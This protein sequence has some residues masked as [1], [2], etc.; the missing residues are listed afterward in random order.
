MGVT[1]LPPRLTGASVSLFWLFFLLPLF[2]IASGFLIANGSIVEGGIAS[3]SQIGRLLA[4]AL[5]IGCMLLVRID[6]RIL[7]LG[8]YPVVVELVMAVLHQR[9]QAFL[10]GL[11]QAYKV[12]YLIFAAVWITTVLQQGHRS[13]IL[14]LIKLNLCIIA[15]MLIISLLF[16]VGVETYGDG[17]GVKGYFASG[18]AVGVYLGGMLILMLALKIHDGARASNLFIL[19]VLIATASVGT[20]T[21][22]LLAASALVFWWV[23][24]GCRA[25]WPAALLS[26]VL[27]YST[28]IVDALSFVYKVVL[29]RWENSENLFH[30]LGS[31]RIEYVTN[32]FK[33]YFDQEVGFF[34][35]LAG[36][37]ASVSYQDISGQAAFDTLETDL[38]DVFFMYGVIGFLLYV[39]FFVLVAYRL[40]RRVFLLIGFL[41]VF[42]HSVLAGHVFFNGMNALLLAL[43]CGI[44]G[45]KERV[46][47]DSA[48]AC[49]TGVS[50]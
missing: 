6:A 41:L 19:Y 43:Y 40:R 30:F 10:V 35:L 12:S 48:A 25:M 1:S 16:G 24:T 14:R 3:P 29:L 26:A 47:N 20:K 50:G 5:M 21:S 34:R 17:G 28:T 46:R 44:S 36:A 38:F 13:M 37:G 22:L 9:S 18:N 32:A 11:V 45:V 27:V 31:G 7:L 33:I 23:S 39:G 8:F 2:D 4:I 49:Q 42:A 15:T